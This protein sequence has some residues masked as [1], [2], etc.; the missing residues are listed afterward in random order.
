G[1]DGECPLPSQISV[2]R[3]DNFCSSDRDCPGS[4]RCCST[5]C[6]RECRLPIGA[7]RGFCPRAPD[8]VSICLVECSSDSQCLGKE[9][10]CSMGCHVQCVQPVPA[11]PGVCPKRKVLQTFAP[12]NNSCT[13]DT[14]CPGH[15]KCC[16]TG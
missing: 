16:F 14:D 11:K 3:C 1:R 9:K 7:K 12:C 15:K 13:D 2:G 8:L 4:E 6:G 5:G 10:C